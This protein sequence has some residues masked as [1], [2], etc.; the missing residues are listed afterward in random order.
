MG[1]GSALDLLTILSRS[2]DC[3]LLE[4]VDPKDPVG[5]GNLEDD[6]VPEGDRPQQTERSFDLDPGF[7]LVADRS[8]PQ[9]LS[10]GE[11]Y[12]EDTLATV[13]AASLH[14]SAHPVFP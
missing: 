8:L 4:K 12:C 11:L 10:G 6:P 2:T 1:P 9:S 7:L 5:P 13:S 14:G 3:F